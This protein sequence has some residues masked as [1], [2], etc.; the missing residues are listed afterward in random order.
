M[1]AR[2]DEK[3]VC[4]ADELDWRLTQ[5]PYSSTTRYGFPVLRSAS[6]SAE[7]RCCR[8]SNI[9]WTCKSGDFT[10]PGWKNVCTW[11]PKILRNGRRR[12]RKRRKHRASPRDSSTK[13][14]F[15]TAT[16]ALCNSCNFVTIFNVARPLA[17]GS[18]QRKPETSLATELQT[19]QQVAFLLHRGSFLLQDR[20]HR[21][22]RP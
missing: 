21:H 19:Q 5:T 13:F 16:C 9:W 11:I 22:Q 15:Q 4:V 3:A 18:V 7:E 2:G 12:F 6:G 17:S 14:V 8:A 20:F 1:A 10:M